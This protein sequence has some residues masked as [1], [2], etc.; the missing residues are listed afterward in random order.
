VFELGVRQPKPLWYV[1]SEIRINNVSDLHELFEDRPSFGR[2]HV[3]IHAAL[4]SVERLK[5]QAVLFLLERHYVSTD[6]A[7]GP[8]ILKLDDLGTEFRE[9]QRSPRART[10]LF[11]RDYP[12]ILEWPQRVIPFYSSDKIL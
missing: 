3:E 8:W 7:A 4:V 1:T 5:E 11:D 6:V 10:I 2:R 9:V 12:N